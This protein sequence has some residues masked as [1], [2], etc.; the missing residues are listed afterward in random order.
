M[1]GKWNCGAV[2]ALLLMLA[3]VVGQAPA[4]APDLAKAEELLRAN[5]AAEAFDLLEPFEFDEAGNLKYD[6]LLGLAALESG[7]PD[8]ATL[9]F[10]R[11]LALEPRYLGVRLD[12]G[13]AYF[14]IGDLARATQEFQT[15]LGQTPPPDLKATAERYIAAIEQAQAPKRWNVSAYLELGYGR[16]SNA[17][18]S[19]ST[20]PINVPGSNTPQF[21]GTPQADNYFTGGLGG[22]VGYQI[23]SRWSLYAGGDARYR[24]Y[25]DVDTADN[26]TL[27]G[28]A[29][30]GLNLG[31]NF[32]RAG[33]VTGR[34]FL[35]NLA[36]RDSWGPNAEWRYQA[37]ERDQLSVNGQ[38]V[39]YR[40]LPDIQVSN[41]FDQGLVG[42]GW[43]HVLGS[44]RTLFSFN[45]NGG[46]EEDTDGRQDGPAWLYGAR[47]FGQTAI[48]DSLGAFA[49]LGAQRTEYGKVNDTYD[50]Q[51]ADWLYDATFGLNW[52]FAKDWSVRPQVMLLKNVSN[53]SVDSFRRADVALNLRKDF[54]WP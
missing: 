31:R 6:Y 41:S 40:Y 35:D 24:A 21:L 11:V 23:T 20:N 13:R 47:F 50:I 15:V 36:Y 30:V 48:T 34:Y 43:L 44:G 42:L 2:A 12:L 26:G 25:R 33:M 29:G 22:E 9:V 7:K 19:T 14:Q 1:G 53:I 28:R 32:F 16:D 52:Q 46:H 3:L 51:R 39:K 45:L 37:G 18:S 10:E 54:R 4:A 17:N 27:D 38:Y 49:T 8:K 5:R